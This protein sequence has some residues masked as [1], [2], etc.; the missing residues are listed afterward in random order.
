MFAR[1]CIFADSESNPTLKC[2]VRALQENTYRLA[3]EM[4]ATMTA[5][6]G[7]LPQ[8]FDAGAVRYMATG[9]LGDD[10]TDMPRVIAEALNQV[11]FVVYQLLL[12]SFF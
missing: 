4:M 11:C 10:P 6:G 12:Y 1:Q 3:G 2:N 7:P 8:L 5:Q 9:C